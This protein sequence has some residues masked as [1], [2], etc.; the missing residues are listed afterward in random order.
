MN[1]N[2]LIATLLAATIAT[3]CA[4]T[5]GNPSIVADR[6]TD[7]SMTCAEILKEYE[8][9]GDKL[10]DAKGSEGAKKALMF[11]PIVGLLAIGSSNLSAIHDTEARMRN[12]AKLGKSK[13]C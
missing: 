11:V 12:L 5:G 3:G 10:K 4:T 13:N 7:N 1:S 6:P 9:M 8:E 2:T